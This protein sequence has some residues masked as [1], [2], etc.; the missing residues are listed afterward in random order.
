MRGEAS[1]ESV[2][3]SA[4]ERESYK[5]ELKLSGGRHLLGGRASRRGRR[6]L[7]MSGISTEPKWWSVVGGMP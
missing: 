7:E 4:L 6:R 3:C 5:H 1:A 2:D